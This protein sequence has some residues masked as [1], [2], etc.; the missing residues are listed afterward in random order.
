MSSFGVSAPR[1][2]V[3][4]NWQMWYGALSKEVCNSL[5]AELSQQEAVEAT[6]FN[7]DSSVRSSK[8]RW[9]NGR[10]DIKKMLYSFALTANRNAFNVDISDFCEIQFTEYDAES[11]GHYGWHH[12]VNIESLSPYDRK[13]SIVVQLSDAGSYDGGDFMF[14][15][16]KSPEDFKLRHQGTVLVFPSFLRHRVTTVTRGVRH[17]LVAWF[18]GPKWR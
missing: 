12:D 13:L 14:D 16:V 15:E 7:S 8:I 18:E 3:R 4:Q 10:D 5:A 1:V 17:S 2:D 6:T 9:V 11:G